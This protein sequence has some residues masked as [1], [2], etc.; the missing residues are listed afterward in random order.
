[1]PGIHRDGHEAEGARPGKLLLETLHLEALQRAGLGALRVDEVREPD[2]A[3][4][5]GEGHGAPVALG[6]R[7]SGTGP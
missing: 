3:A 1:M 7:K 4:K 6:S 2:R 5:I